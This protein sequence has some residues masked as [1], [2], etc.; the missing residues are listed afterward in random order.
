MSREPIIHWRNAF[1]LI[2]FFAVMGVV[3]LAAKWFI[4]ETQYGLWIVW[5]FMGPFIAYGLIVE[6]MRRRRVRLGLEEDVE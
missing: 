4:Y 1:A 5:A 6:A 3:A 2:L